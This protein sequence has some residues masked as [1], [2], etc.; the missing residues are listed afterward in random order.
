MLSSKAVSMFRPV[1]TRS[2]LSIRRPSVLSDIESGSNIGNFA[3]RRLFS[4]TS[5]TMSE[6]QKYEYVAII[7]DKLDALERRV[8]VRATHL[9]NVKRMFDAGI[10]V[11]GG[12]YLD[13]PV[14]ES[15]T[16]S[17]KGSVVNIIAESTEQVKEI[18]SQDPYTLNDVWDWEKA[19]IF[20]FICAVRKGKP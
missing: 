3:C 19:Q 10:M 11:S 16:P 8:A 6:P 17:F 12:V 20:N 15:S 1:I 9:E 5:T 4:V 14:I 18:L 2:K 13:G 7:P